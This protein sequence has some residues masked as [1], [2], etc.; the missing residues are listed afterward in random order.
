LAGRFLARGGEVG[1]AQGV[2]TIIWPKA[3]II[4]A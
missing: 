4:S 1:I 3:F 2:R